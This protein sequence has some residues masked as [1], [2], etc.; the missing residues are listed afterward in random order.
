MGHPDGNIGRLDG[1]RA[2]A[3][4]PF[5]SA[6]RVRTGLQ[7]GLQTR[8]S[9]FIASE[10]TVNGLRTVSERCSRVLVLEFLTASRPDGYE[11]YPDACTS[12]ALF[13][14]FCSQTL[15]NTSN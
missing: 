4:S 5:F 9:E 7:T 8:L 6:R 11:S 10:G 1:A 15:A 14:P 3:L 13:F 12:L 2:N